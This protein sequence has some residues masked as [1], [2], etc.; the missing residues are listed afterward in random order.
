MVQ[1]QEQK[2]HLAQDSFRRLM[3]RGA[4]GHALNLL[5]KLHAADLA[6][7]LRHMDE[8]EKQT[9]FGMIQEDRERAAQ[10][11]SECDDQTAKELLEPMQPADMAALF[12]EMEADDVT[13][14]I[15]LFPDDK[16][17]EVLDIL[18]AQ[19]AEPVTDLLQY[20]E[21]TAGGIMTPHC[22]ALPEEMT[23]GEAITHVRKESEAETVFYIYVVDGDNHLEG[24]ISLRQL[25]LAPPDATLKGLARSEVYR[26]YTD[27]DQEEV[28]RLVS[29]YDLLA[30]PVVDHESRLVGIVTV[31][32]V[33]DVIRAEATEDI[34]KMAGTHDEEILTRSAFRVARYRLP[35][36]LVGLAAGMLTARVIAHFIGVLRDQI[37]LAAFMPLI[38]GMGG[39]VGNQSATV[40]VR[41]IAT[42]RLDPKQWLQI[43]WKQFQVGVLLGI[44]VA[45]LLG[46]ITYLLYPD[47]PWLGP[48]VGLA[49][50]LGIM[51][52]AVW[53]VLVPLAFHWLHI[54]PAVATQPFVSTTIDIVSALIY[55]A[56]ASLLLF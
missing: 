47:N 1:S 48:T 44:A 38:L 13:D 9:T 17:K 3:R 56:T 18:H 45:L 6:Q 42:G 14:L 16:A 35:W 10:V 5:E 54:D 36:L 24:V 43:V 55:F 52:A 51:A 34:L 29:R 50:L 53:S 31:D 19:V 49:I 26:V 22:L 12:Q 11:L 27:T 23:A 32:D 37:Y 8:E 20:G 33:I 46:G 40:L 7:I 30:L 41:G 4:T 2:I 21:K 25:L 28:A 15:A 39:I